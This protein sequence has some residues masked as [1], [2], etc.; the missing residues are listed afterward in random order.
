MWEEGSLGS[1]EVTAFGRAKRTGMVPSNIGST[2]HQEG[3]VSSSFCGQ[4][5]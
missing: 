3:K 1:D 5:P 2:S 4:A